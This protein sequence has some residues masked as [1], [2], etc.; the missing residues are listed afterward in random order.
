MRHWRKGDVSHGRETGRA[1][2]RPQAGR[3]E[4]REDALRPDPRL[5]YDRDALGMHLLSREAWT[6]AEPQFRR[7]V[8]LNP[9]EPEFKQHLAWCLYR[10]GRYAEALG[11]ARESLAQRD[12]ADT[13]AMMELIEKGLKEHPA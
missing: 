13:R 3:E 9:F 10:Q 6:V 5:G 4:R 8:W 11:W 12:T 2:G 1:K 7:A